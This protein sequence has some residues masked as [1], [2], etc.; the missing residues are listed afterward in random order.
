MV[1]RA[2]NPPSARRSDRAEL[3]SRVSVELVS[4][5]AWATT[6]GTQAD[7]VAGEVRMLWGG[8]VGGVLCIGIGAA[9]V[10]GVT[11]AD[12][13]PDG[14][15]TPGNAVTTNELELMA[16]PGWSRSADLPSIP[17]L[18]PSRAVAL[19]DRA[20]G[21]H[22]LAASLPASS[23]AL[24]PAELLERLDESLKQARRVRLGGGLTA[25]YYSG[26]SLVGEPGPT[27]R[28]RGADDGGRRDGGV[29]Q[30]QRLPPAPLAGMP[31]SG[32]RS[33]RLA[34]RCARPAEPGHGVL[35]S[36]RGRDARR[37]RGA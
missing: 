3:R 10:S 32:E 26:L 27:R 12:R 20:S 18:S 31:R 15:R 9:T 14:P 25:Y 33:L 24:L 13:Q 5:G 28:V 6:S 8:V 34:A 23:T 29:F 17:G 35:A 16:P 22:I 37:R 4:C 30:R 2:P 19:V 21:A 7:M 1:A 36:D 11:Q